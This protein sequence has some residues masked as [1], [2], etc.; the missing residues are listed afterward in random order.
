MVSAPRFA[1]V[2]GSSRGIGRAIAL[3]LAERGHNIAVHYHTREMAAEE[4]LAEI[5][6]RGAD[7]FIVSADL[8]H[9]DEIHRMLAR[10]DA[11]FGGLNVLVSNARPELPGFYQPPMDLTLPAWETAMASQAR[12]FLIAVQASAALLRDG[13]R[14]VAITYS[15]STRYGSWQPWAAM[16]AAKAALETLARYF[17]VALGPRGITVNCVSPGFVLGQAGTLD[18]TVINTLPPEAQQA[19]RDWHEGGWTPMRRLATPAEIGDA[20]GLLCAREAGFITGQ[21][22]HVDGGA[23]LMDAFSPLQLQGIQWT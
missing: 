14:I 2:T 10:V 15:P 13:G 20:V 17:A 4:V 8:T 7:G 21:T 1:L 5:R 22:L 16:G 12:A 9:A 3:A 23:S 11:E 18:E 6:A 19:I